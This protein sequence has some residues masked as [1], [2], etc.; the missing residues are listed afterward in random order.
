MSS[1]RLQN[2][3]SILSQL[4][5][6]IKAARINAALKVNNEL[7]NVYWEVGKVISEQENSDGWGAKVVD[8][9]ARD[10]KTEFP[11]MQGFSTRNL[12]Y[13]RDFYLAYPQFLILQQPAASFQVAGNQNDI[14]LQQVAAKLPWGHHQ[15]ILD[16][17]KTP[18][19]RFFYITKCAENSWSRNILIHQIETRL[20][21]RQ[22]ALTNNFTSTMPAIQ[23]ELAQQVFKDPYQLD[24]IMLGVEAKER[25]LENALQIHITQFLLELGEGFAFMGRQKKLLVNGKEFFIDLLFYNTKLRRHIIIELKIGEF[26]P[27]YV[28]KMNFYLGAFDDTLKGEY[29]EPSIGLILCK[30]KDKVIAE[31]ALR[32]TSKPIGISEYRINSI[33]P[34]D[35]KGEIPSVEELESELDKRIEESKS[36]AEK[37]LDLLKEKINRI[38]NEELNITANH[39]ILCNLYDTGIKPLFKILLERLVE[40]DQYFMSS[41]RLW[42]DVNENATLDEV[43][44]VWKNK[45]YLDK[46][47]TLSFSCRFDGFKKAGIKAFGVYMSI[48]FVYDRY[49]YGFSFENKMEHTIFQRLY[50]QPMKDEDINFIS[51]Q[52]C[53]KIIDRINSQLDQFELAKDDNL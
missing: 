14:I 28:S 42:S 40:F 11:D 35:I 52:F 12:R 30:T 44:L 7:L 27:E 32:D 51:D 6:K 31:Y 1:N 25:D 36:P 2:Y 33:L 15:V 17:V 38:K 26:E 23:G 48:Y 53:E 3:G 19:E 8:Q 16:K 43:D 39:E 20:H 21:E 45:E 4:K 50:H 46:S 10:L 13:M 29:D 9:L 41:F 22:G 37:K 49:K 34:E 47:P 24:F 5:E 18:S